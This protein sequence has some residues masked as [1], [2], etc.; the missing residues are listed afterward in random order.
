MVEKQKSDDQ[1]K[2]DNKKL[3]QEK[4]K[5]AKQAAAEEKKRLALEEK[6]K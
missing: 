1:A 5:L 3:D 2:A 6:Q 4:A